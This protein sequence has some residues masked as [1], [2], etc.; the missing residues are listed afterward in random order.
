MTA[1][2]NPRA[3]AHVP[4]ER[5]GDDDDQLM[6][7][8][9]R[10][11]PNRRLD[12]GLTQNFPLHREFAG[13]AGKILISHYFGVGDGCQRKDVDLVLSYGAKLRTS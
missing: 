11:A 8:F 9:A 1:A 10:G 7:A 3:H 12:A 4:R 5:F 6:A 2:Q 13:G